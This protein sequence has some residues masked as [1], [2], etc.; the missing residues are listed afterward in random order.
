MNGESVI[1]M[2]HNKAVAL[3]K[4]ARG[5]VNIAVS[6]PQS[7]PTSAK[8]PVADSPQQLMEKL[9]VRVGEKGGCGCVS[10]QMCSPQLKQEMV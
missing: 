5:P 3:I 8:K 10:I 4:R 1:G 6:R 9:K 2:A 7:R